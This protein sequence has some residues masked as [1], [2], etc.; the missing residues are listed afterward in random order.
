MPMVWYAL[1][2]SIAFLVMALAFWYGG[3]LIA[4]G[5]CSTEQFFVIYVAIVFG[6]E[7]AGQFFA[8]TP[9][10]KTEAPFR[11]TQSDTTI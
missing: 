5:E 6:G 10:K 1:A 11:R 2:E 8:Y 7:A 9:S 4:D 3:Q